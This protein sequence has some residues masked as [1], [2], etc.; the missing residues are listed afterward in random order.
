MDPFIRN[1]RIKNIYTEVLENINE[2]NEVLSIN[3]NFVNFKIIHLNI[4]SIQKNFEELEAFLSEFTSEFEC[5]AL[6]ETWKIENIQLFQLRGY[7]LNLTKM[8]VLYC[9]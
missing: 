6:S 5:I 7:N 9:L 3:G 2:V 4:R 1:Y 8:M